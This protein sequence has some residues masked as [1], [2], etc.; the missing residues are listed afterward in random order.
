[1]RNESKSEKL[2]KEMHLKQQEQVRKSI[3]DLSWSLDRADFSDIVFVFTKE[4]K[5]YQSILNSN[6]I[7]TVYRLHAHRCILYARSDSFRELLASEWSP[8][9]I[10]IEDVKCEIFQAIMKFVYRY[11]GIVHSPHR[12][13]ESLQRFRG[14]W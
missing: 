3:S 13:N 2:S 10:V 12:I 9:E 6:L 8:P 4:N 5:R 1:M 11:M 7:L 14:R